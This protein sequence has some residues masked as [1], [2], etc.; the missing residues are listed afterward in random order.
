MREANKTFK[1]KQRVS[2]RDFDVTGHYIKEPTGIFFMYI[3]IYVRV[4]DKS[5]G[6]I[7]RGLFI[8]Y[9]LRLCLYCS[10]Y[11][12]FYYFACVVLCVILMST[13]C[14]CFFSSS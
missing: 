2:G 10:V 13:F 8:Y 7:P 4:R 12:I 3:Y 11:L 6:T 14:I 9:M 5:A 1:Q